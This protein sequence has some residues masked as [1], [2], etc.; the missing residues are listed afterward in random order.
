[1]SSGYEFQW[2]LV[3]D[4]WPLLMAGAW[5]DVRV[6][7]IGFFLACLIGLLIALIRSEKSRVAAVPAIAYVEIARG[8]PPY[9]CL[10]WV[11]FGLAAFM[12]IR[13]TAIQSITT[14][15]A[16]TGSGY[17]AEIFRSGIAA[18]DRGQVEAARSLGMG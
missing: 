11:H 4:R 9:V 15:L 10:L 16:F 3:F 8:I 14:V 18:I 17:T 5:I 6:T 7:I 2:A 13:F 12:D 1:M